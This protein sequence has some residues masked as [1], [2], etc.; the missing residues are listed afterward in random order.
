M[1]ERICFVLGA[2]SPHLAGCLSP[3]CA[4]HYETKATNPEQ[5]H[6]QDGDLSAIIPQACGGCSTTAP[7]SPLATNAASSAFLRSRSCAIGCQDSAGN[8]SA[9]HAAWSGSSQR[10]F[11]AQRNPLPVCLTRRLPDVARPGNSI[12]RTPYHQAVRLT[13]Q[14]RSSREPRRSLRQCA[15]LESDRTPQIKTRVPTSVRERRAES[16]PHHHG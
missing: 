4:A 15:P 16:Q 1:C 5:R 2:I 3:D 6:D 8:P 14:L 7:W 11:A 9:A 12:P 13:T 10:R